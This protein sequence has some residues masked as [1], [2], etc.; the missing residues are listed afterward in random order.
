MYYLRSF[1]W[2]VKSLISKKDSFSE[3]R[4]PGASSATTFANL[5]AAV[6]N[7]CSV[8]HA[9]NDRMVSDRKELI[10]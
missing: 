5:F 4:V 8:L 2:L 7:L 9:V 3:D 1:R 6:F 10:T